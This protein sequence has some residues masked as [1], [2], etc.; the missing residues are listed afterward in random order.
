LK[1]ISLREFAPHSSPLTKLA[2]WVLRWSGVSVC[3]L[4]CC[5]GSAVYG[6]A[7]LSN[8]TQPWD[9][10]V[11]YANTR[12]VG[13]DFSTGPNRGSIDGLALS[14]I[15]GGSA[16]SQSITYSVMLYSVGADNLPAGFYL[17]MDS[18]VGATWADPVGQGSFQ[19]QTFTYTAAQLP[20]LCASVLEANSKYA[21]VLADNS[22]Y[23]AGEHYLALVSPGTSYTTAGGFSFLAFSR[24]SDGGA[25]WRDSFDFGKPIASI[26]FNELSPVPEPS[27]WAAMSFGLLGIVWVVRGHRR[28]AARGVGAW[29]ALARLGLLPACKK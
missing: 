22:G 20:H 2:P 14:L 29:V 21:I 3:A 5:A 6:A 7:V 25:S 28:L 1:S 26:S 18:N 13:L 23:P 11:G 4:A 15:A 19:Q 27:E 8:I 17:A 12:Q 16:T 10:A 24:S 9:G